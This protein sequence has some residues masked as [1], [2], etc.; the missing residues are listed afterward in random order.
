MKTKEEILKILKSKKGFLKK[1]YKV[2]NIALFGSYV[3]GENRP[4]S[5]ID[6]LVEFYEPI[7]L[8]KFIELENYLSGILG[9]KVDLVVKSALKKNVRKQVLQEML[10]V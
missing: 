2:K 6:I 9:T 4:T 5:D 3:R 10:E 1:K 7:S 8:L